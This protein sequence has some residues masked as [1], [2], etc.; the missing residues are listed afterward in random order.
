MSKQYLKKLE[1]KHPMQAPVLLSRQANIQQTGMITYKYGSV[2]IRNIPI[3]RSSKF[4]AVDGCG[5]SF[6]DMSL[7][8]VNLVP[9]SSQIPLG[10]NYGQV[11]LLTLYCIPLLNKITLLKIQ[12]LHP[13]ENPVTFVLPN[14]VSFSIVELTMI[15]LADE[16]ADELYSYSGTSERLHILATNIEQDSAEFTATG[17]IILQGLK[18]IKSEVYKRKA[19]VKHSSSS[20]FISDMDQH[21]QNILQVFQDIGVNDQNLKMLTPLSLLLSKDHVHR[22]HQHWVEEDRWNLL[23]F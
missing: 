5:G 21:A 17:R 4:M 11:F 23:L 2:D 19:K 9:T 8:D 1:K 15:T 18:L 13:T 20:P 7:D 10:S 6:V 16:I 14:G 3:L 12:P 22:S